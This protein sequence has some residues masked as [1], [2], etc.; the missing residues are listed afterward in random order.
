MKDLKFR[1][2][3]KAE[4]QQSLRCHLFTLEERMCGKYAHSD[5]ED[6]EQYTGRKD[7]D[8]REIF[9]GDILKGFV[10]PETVVEVTWG[11]TEWLVFDGNYNPLHI[12]GYYDVRPRH[13]QVIGNIHQNPD[14]RSEG[15]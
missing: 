7:R 2:C 15:R 11:D 8:G 14:I 6:W 9:A 5:F 3:Q 1:A 10:E 13:L 4:G 12:E